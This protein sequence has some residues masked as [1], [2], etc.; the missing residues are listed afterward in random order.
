[1]GVTQ[2]LGDEKS[3]LYGKK[4]VLT[5][6]HGTHETII[7]VNIFNVTSLYLRIPKN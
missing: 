2:L 4:Y 5:I 7:L 1:M 6:Q 3:F